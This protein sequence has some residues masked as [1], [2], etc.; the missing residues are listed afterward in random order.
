MPEALTPF[1]VASSANCRFQE[2]KP[3][4]VLPHC[5]ASALAPRHARTARMNAAVVNSL[6]LIIQNSFAKVS[7]GL[8]RGSADLRYGLTD[9]FFAAAASDLERKSTARYGQCYHRYPL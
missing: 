3:V 4:A 6:R 7:C 5:A 9:G 8:R 1:P 2:S